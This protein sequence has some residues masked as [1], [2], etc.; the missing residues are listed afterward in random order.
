MAGERF[1]RI[2]AARSDGGESWSAARL[3]GVCQGIVDV[4][5]AGVMLMSGD[6]PRGS[7]CSTDEGSQLIEELQDTLGEGPGV[8][9]Y[10]QA[11]AG[12]EPDLAEPASLRWPGFPG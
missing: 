1:R 10:P 3:C 2:L 4:S 5:G 12:A 7:L 6:M 8:D 9:A 11:E